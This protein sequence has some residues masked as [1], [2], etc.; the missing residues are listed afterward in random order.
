MNICLGCSTNRIISNSLFIGYK[1]Y[2]NVE[3]EAGK[4]VDFL[5]CGV[6]TGRAVTRGKTQRILFVFVKEKYFQNFKIF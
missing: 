1:S 6:S 4:E 3:T 5:M 2:L